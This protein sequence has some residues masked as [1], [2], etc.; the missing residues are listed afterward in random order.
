MPVVNSLFVPSLNHIY[1]TYVCISEAAAVLCTPVVAGV[2]FC[3][4]LI[5]LIWQHSKQH[6]ARGSWYLSPIGLWK[7]NKRVDNHVVGVWTLPALNEFH[8]IPTHVFNSPG[9]LRIGSRTWFKLVQT[10]KKTHRLNYL[11]IIHMYLLSAFHA[12]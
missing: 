1:S 4:F 8:D 9:W 11:N 12:L 7:P 2:V 5:A 6:G 10:S 3:P